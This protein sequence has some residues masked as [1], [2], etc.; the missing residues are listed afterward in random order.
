MHN[1]FSIYKKTILVKIPKIDVF[2]HISSKNAILWVSV[3]NTIQNHKNPIDE[4]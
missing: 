2:G 3:K 4:N 1:F